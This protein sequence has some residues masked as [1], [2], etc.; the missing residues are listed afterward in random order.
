MGNNSSQP[1]FVG[2]SRVDLP[3]YSSYSQP[4]CISQNNTQFIFIM[5]TQTQK[6]LKYNIE[7][8]TFMDPM[9][10]P[11]SKPKLIS[12]STTVDSQN[13]CIYILDGKQQLFMILDATKADNSW[14]I[15]QD[16]TNKCGSF[17]TVCYVSSPFNEFHA[18]GMG[19]H[20]KW[21]STE[22][23]FVEICQL[24][25][26]I[27][28]SALIYIGSKKQ[29]FLMGGKQVNNSEY[30]DDIYV[31]DY[32]DDK[33]KWN[34][35]PHIKLP[36]KMAKFGCVLY[37]ERY[38]ILFGGEIA[39]KTYLDT[40][41]VFDANNYATESICAWIEVDLICPQANIY[42]AV[43]NKDKIHLFQ[44]GQ[45]RKQWAIDANMLFTLKQRSLT[46]TSE[47]YED[48]EEKMET[49]D[50]QKIKQDEKSEMKN[51]NNQEQKP[52]L[53]EKDYKILQLQNEI[54]SQKDMI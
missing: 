18:I 20:L 28:H 33:W 46:I 6:W 49:V 3:P 53:S 9:K 11:I 43:Q 45:Q 17:P 42:F 36:H 12:H 30:V 35:L 24:N 26:N 27:Q 16:F 4:V 40:I 32:I 19:K 14:S 10:Y 41:Y 39:E 51:T 31:A 7:S 23:D 15:Y 2:L 52:N 47:K 25:K 5:P 21:N 8:N 50:E 38:I 29:L 34:K 37:E 48:I 54:K 22:H 13:K 1:G 44:R